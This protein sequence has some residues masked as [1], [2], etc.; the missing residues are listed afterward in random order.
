MKQARSERSV[1]DQLHEH[2]TSNNLY[3]IFQSAYM[4]Y[5]STETAL[6]KLQNDLLLNMDR[7]HTSLS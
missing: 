6:L 7:D 5:H 4:A 1:F 2:L 3:P